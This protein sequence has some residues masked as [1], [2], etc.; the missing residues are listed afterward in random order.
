MAAT[1]PKKSIVNP[2]LVG[3]DAV[4]TAGVSLTRS[5]TG[6]VKTDVFRVSSNLRRA[7]LARRA[8]STDA[9]AL[10]PTDDAA[11]PAPTDVTVALGRQVRARLSRRTAGDDATVLVPTDED[12]AA[13]GPTDATDAPGRQV[14]TPSKRRRDGPSAR[15]RK[16]ARAE[17][18]AP[19]PVDDDIIDEEMDIDAAAP[20]AHDDVALSDATPE[21][22]DD[23]GRGEDGDDLTPADAEKLSTNDNEADAD[24]K[25]TN[26]SDDD[27]DALGDLMRDPQS[28][29][30]VF[31]HRAADEQMVGLDLAER[32]WTTT[33]QI[34]GDYPA[35]QKLAWA[36]AASKERAYLVVM[37]GSKYFT[38]I[39]H[40]TVLN[41]ELRPKDPVLGRVVAFEAEMRDDGAPPRLVLFEGPATDLFRVIR[42]RLGSRSTADNIYDRPGPNDTSF[43]GV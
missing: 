8:A 42:P 27:L 16:Q 25:S 24:G 20:D 2:T 1:P 40:L 10:G 33:R 43:I 22:S 14:T 13:P 32:V 12:A 29:C 4:G 38:L 26:D 11:E 19:A 30:S 7:R 36:T 39:H 3:V 6:L 23:E 17:I 28:V 5:G 18:A 9:T 15:K 34:L 21:V 35:A 37:G 31:A 41:V